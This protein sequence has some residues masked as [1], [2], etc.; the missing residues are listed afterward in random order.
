VLCLSLLAGGGG[1]G[2][3]ELG[4]NHGT[5]EAQMSRATEARLR[6]RN[7]DLR[8]RIGE[9][10]DRIAL[11]E[12]SQSIDER[13]V[14]R[15]HE[16]LE[17][18]EQQIGQLEEELAFYRSLVSPS[19]SD[20]GIQIDRV[21]LF[22]E[23]DGRYRYEIVLT[24]VDEDDT[25]ARG[26]VDLT[27][28]GTRDSETIRLGFSELRADSESVATFEFSYFQALSGRLQLPE[29]FTPA[30]VRVVVTPDGE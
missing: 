10:M 23:G 25:K 3:Y 30:S 7:D 27:V 15:I 14:D 12:R 20:D 19:G 24:R 13:S 8:S 11:L 17:R 28:R 4:R 1:W 22:D 9:L 6:I 16:Q 5:T 2:M 18:R 26:N 29:E 21:S